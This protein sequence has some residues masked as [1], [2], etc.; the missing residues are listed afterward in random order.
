MSAKKPVPFLRQVISVTK[1]VS[2]SPSPVQ[3]LTSLSDAYYHRYSNGAVEDDTGCFWRIG[4][5]LLSGECR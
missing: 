3:E 4:L 5:G 1:K 2:V